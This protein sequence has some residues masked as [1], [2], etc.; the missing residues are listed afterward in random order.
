MACIPFALASCSATR[1]TTAPSQTES[2]ISTE[3]PSATPSLSLPPYNISINPANFTTEITNPYEPFPAGTTY[4]YD[5]T[6]DGVPRRAEVTVTNETKL[7]M[8]VRCVIVRDVVTSKNAL[9]EKT[10]DWYAQDKAGNVWYFGEDTKEYTNGAVTSTA[11]TWEAGVD[12]ALPGIV[13]KATPT[14]G[15][16]YRQEYRPGQAEDFAKVIK[17]NETLTVPAGKYRNVV[18]T[19]DTD[20]LDPSKLENK[21]FAPSVGFVRA[22]GYVNGHHEDVR[23]SSVLK[24]R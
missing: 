20:L 17:R 8:G 14:V 4:V 22:S 7:I 19:E 10:T 9:V 12:G 2:P 24:A 3:V 13:M 18:V 15:D 1:A 16:A 5:G 21:F 6:R 11:G 23:L